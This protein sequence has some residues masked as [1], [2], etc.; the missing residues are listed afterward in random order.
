MLNDNENTS[1][2]LS[3]GTYKQSKN[4]S[5]QTLT[6]TEIA[7]Y[8]AKGHVFYP[9][10]HDLSD[11]TIKATT[12]MSQ[13][14]I[15]VDFDNSKDNPCLKTMEQHVSDLEAIGFDIAIAYKTQSHTAECPK[16]R[17]IFI[18][19]KAYT[20]YSEE[21][22]RGTY[23]VYQ[24]FNK[25]HKDVLV[26]T[27]CNDAS[28]LF[29]GGLYGE[30]VYVNEN[31][32]PLNLREVIQVASTYP[33]LPTVAKPNVV[34]PT[35]FKEY[36]T[37]HVTAVART[38]TPVAKKEAVK[39][40]HT[41][42]T[43]FE[44][45]KAFKPVELAKH[46]E[47]QDD[48]IPGETNVKK[49]MNQLSMDTLF[50][51]PVEQSFLDVFHEEE[52]PSAY[53]YRNKVD[54]FSCFSTSAEKTGYTVSKMIEEVHGSKARSFMV[55]FMN[56]FNKKPA[57]NALEQTVSSN[58]EFVKSDRFKEQAPNAYKIFN[59]YGFGRRILT[60]QEVIAS[61]TDGARMTDKDETSAFFSIKSIVSAAYGTRAASNESAACELMAFA[62]LT[63]F[64][65][66][67]SNESLTDETVIKLEQQRIRTALNKHVSHDSVKRLTV[68][69]FTDLASLTDSE[70]SA[71][72][73][74]AKAVLAKGT[75]VSK[76][77]VAYVIG[78][79]GESVAKEIYPTERIQLSFSQQGRNCDVL[80]SVKKHLN[81]YGHV[82]KSI[83]EQH[84]KGKMSRRQFENAYIAAITELGLVTSSAT[85]E[86]QEAFEI[87]VSPRARISYDP[88]A[89]HKPEVKELSAFMENVMAYV[90]LETG[91]ILEETAAIETTQ[92]IEVSPD[93]IEVE[94][95]MQLD[96]T[97]S[98]GINNAQVVDDFIYIETP[99]G[100]I[101]ITKDDL[102]SADEYLAT[103]EV[104]RSQTPFSNCG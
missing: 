2:P 15:V 23:G 38:T 21:L 104:K 81:Q 28:R 45:M 11:T 72:D 51:L 92:V 102:A 63:G 3:Y 40:S 17:F 103:K 47:A 89:M 96:P 74:R 91:E 6:L 79:Y 36:N 29:N 16:Y 76:M 62:A 61:R 9:S 58:R 13:Q 78:A 75:S 34:K 82:F 66:K 68:Y 44:L 19:D 93:V 65:T 97:H 90:N 60:V 14:L 26:D 42:H 88:Q 31:A 57:T 8:M 64:A 52:N 54:M 73:E 67:H 24:F 33:I 84:F 41:D 37:E 71:L 80:E 53:I 39:R 94:N 18:I 30:S 43:G 1:K 22:R 5:I 77:S 101:V 35:V 25:G 27:K 12:F 56:A 99:D 7:Q 86:V 98:I 69:S 55:Q 83:I 59:R 48:F 85:A 32:K 10:I 87:N 20:S 49:F 50:D 4:L 100:T 95:V 46:Y 70:L